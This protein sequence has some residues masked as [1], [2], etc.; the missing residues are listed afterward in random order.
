[1]GISMGSYSTFHISFLEWYVP[2]FLSSSWGSFLGGG[3]TDSCKFIKIRNEIFLRYIRILRSRSLRPIWYSSRHP[4][5]RSII[6]NIR[7][8]RC[9][10]CPPLEQLH[11]TNGRLAVITSILPHYFNAIASSGYG[12]RH[13]RR[14]CSDYGMP[15]TIIALTGFAYWGRFNPYVFPSFYIKGCWYQ[16]REWGKHDPTHQLSIIPSGK[17]QKLVSPFLGITRKMGRN[18]IPIRIRIMDIIL[19]RP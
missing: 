11:L 9:I 2:F 10:V 17:R 8:P 12:N 1:M 5:I 13:I 18:R 19:F 15:I 4:S 7:Y 14:F 16:V 6:R 3:L